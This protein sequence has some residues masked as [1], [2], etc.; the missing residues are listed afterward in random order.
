MNHAKSSATDALKTALK[1]A[2]RR[3]KKQLTI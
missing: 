2:T 1:K 3:Q